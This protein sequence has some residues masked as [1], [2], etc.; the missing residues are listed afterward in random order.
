MQEIIDRY[1]ISEDGTIRNPRTGRELKPYITL[2]KSLQPYYRIS[3]YVPS[4]KKKKNFKRSRLVAFKY[5]NPPYNWCELEVDHLD[6][7]TV[8]DSKD[9]LKWVTPKENKNSWRNK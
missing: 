9:N 3:L 6:R 7:D 8:H 4:L 1:E 2:S 5:C